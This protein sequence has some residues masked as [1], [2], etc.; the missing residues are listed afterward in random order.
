MGK[1]L[2]IPMRTTYANLTQSRSS[3]SLFSTL[4]LRIFDFIIE[5]T[6]SAAVFF[7]RFSLGLRFTQHKAVG[8]S[9]CIPDST[10]V[11]LIYD[12]MTRSEVHLSKIERNE[13]IRNK[14]IVGQLRSW[15]K[16]YCPFY[17]ALTRLHTKL[18]CS[19]F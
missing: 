11:L 3:I 2:M 8:S 15:V 6:S 13:V 18:I 5:L 19:H 14:R 16:I 1:H 4:S 9:T 7:A 10:E 12:A 17:S